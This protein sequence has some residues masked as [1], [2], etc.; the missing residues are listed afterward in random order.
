MLKLQDVVQCGPRIIVVVVVVVIVVVVVVV[1]V[2]VVVVVVVNVVI[3][4]VVVCLC[5]IVCQNARDIH[6]LVRWFCHAQLP[7]QDQAERDKD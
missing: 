4:F 5:L 2:V 3:I 7:L 1:A 6:R